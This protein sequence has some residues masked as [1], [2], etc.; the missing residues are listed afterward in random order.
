MRCPRCR[1]VLVR[2]EC[3]TEEGCWAGLACI[4]CGYV[5][6]RVMR[7]HKQTRPEPYRQIPT[8]RA[9]RPRVPPG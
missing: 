4:L 8:T 5:E 6:D 3:Q 1:N 9:K 7:E 2:S